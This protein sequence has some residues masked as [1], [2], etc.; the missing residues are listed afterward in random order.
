MRFLYHLCAADQ[1]LLANHLMTRG[2]KVADGGPLGKTIVFAK[3][4][5]HVQFLSDRFD[6]SYP[7]YGSEPEFL[8]DGEI[9]SSISSLPSGTRHLSLMSFF[10]TTGYPH[11][12]CTLTK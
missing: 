10:V 7:H 9:T 11:R 6:K 12:S 2:E 1:A 8:Q 5:A 3:N 4:H